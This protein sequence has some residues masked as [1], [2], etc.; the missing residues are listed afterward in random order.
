MLFAQSFFLPSLPPTFVIRSLTQFIHFPDSHFLPYS[1]PTATLAL[2]PLVLPEACRTLAFHSGSLFQHPG[3]RHHAH[4]YVVETTKLHK[5]TMPFFKDLRR[6]SKASF[7]TSDSSNESNGT[8]PTA[9]SSSTLSS[10][11]GTS[12]PSSSVK[13]N[14][15]SSNLAAMRVL[16]ETTPPPVPQRPSTVV[17]ISNRTSVIVRT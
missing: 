3:C 11:N 8:V 4:N 10:T 1:E 2:T 7:R 17:P 5:I 12:T 16:S 9:K 6:R 15:S 13:V 14:G